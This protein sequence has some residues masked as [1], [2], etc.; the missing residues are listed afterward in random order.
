MSAH[1]HKEMCTK[2]LCDVCNRKIEQTKATQSLMS[3]D[4]AMDRCEWIHMYI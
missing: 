3:D 1:M 4:R 2:C